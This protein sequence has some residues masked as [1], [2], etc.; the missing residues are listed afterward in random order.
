MQIR[1]IVKI[2]QGGANRADSQFTSRED[3]IELIILCIGPAE[4]QSDN[5]GRNKRNNP[6]NEI[7]NLDVIQKKYLVC[8]PFILQVQIALH[9]LAIEAAIQASQ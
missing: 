6:N 8:I 5:H 1:F 2:N 4:I 9:C 3:L 7:I